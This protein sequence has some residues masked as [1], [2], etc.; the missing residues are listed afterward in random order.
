MTMADIAPHAR[1]GIL[2]NRIARIH[3][4]D[5]HEAQIETV[6]RHRDSRLL[7]VHCSLRALKHRHSSLI[8]AVVRGAHSIDDPRCANSAAVGRDVLTGLVD[9]GGLLQQLEVA[10]ERARWADSR[11]AVVFVDV[12]RFKAI[13]DSL[14]HLVGDQVLRS[15]ANRLSSSVRPHDTVAR[16]GGDEFVALMTNVESAQAVGRI[17]ARIGRPISAA[18]RLADGKPWRVRVSLSIGVALCGKAMCLPATAIE[19]A[20]RAMYRAKALGRNGNFVIDDLS[21]SQSD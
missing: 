2:A 7:P 10:M 11:Y 21:L 6:L 12:D 19:C 4:G 13:N 20:D 16:F 9:R 17:A 14:G 1:R 5:F 15:V 8:L 3:R 18:G